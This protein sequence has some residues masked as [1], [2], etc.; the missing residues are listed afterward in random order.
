VPHPSLLQRAGQ[1]LARV[2][3]PS[4][5]EGAGFDFHCEPLRTIVAAA[6]RSRCR[7]TPRVS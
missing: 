3:H 2:P 6:F 1:P 4:V 7:R 5:L